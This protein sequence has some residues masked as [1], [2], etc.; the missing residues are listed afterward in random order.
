MF[1]D[2]RDQIQ[3]MMDRDPA[4]R[5][6]LEV[7]LCYPG[8]HAVMLHRLAHAVWQRGWHV[9]GRAISQI[10]RFM[11]GIEIH[12]GAYIGRRLFIDHGM[13]VVIG[14]MSEIGDDVTLYQGVTLGGVAPSV[15]SA[16]Q[17]NQKRHPT[18]E[19]GVIVGSG[20]QILGPVVVGKDARVGANS[21]VVKDVEAGVTVTGIPARV[22]LPRDR[23]ERDRFMPYGTPIV[24]APDPVVRAIEDLRNEI[25]DLRER[26]AEIENVAAVDGDTVR[27][28]PEESAVG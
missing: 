3:G 17:R 25:R 13:G 8:F 27:E 24:D 28:T 10:G 16:A 26:L 19:D 21:V 2:I 6:P 14:E 1:K 7:I 5:S 23:R 15:D 22:L 9:L 12:P 11:T 4:A 18:L 20:A